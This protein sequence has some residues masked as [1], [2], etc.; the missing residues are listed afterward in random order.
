ML[1]SR[2]NSQIQFFEDFKSRT[3][4]VYQINYMMHFLEHYDI[5]GKDVLE[6]GGALP[7]EF[8]IDFLG[9]KSWTCTE[10]SQYD[11]A[12]NMEANQHH[13]TSSAQHSDSYVVHVKNIEDFEPV[14]DERFDCIFSVA[15][16]EHIG[17]LP[18]ALETMYRVLKPGGVLFSL[19]APIWSCATG[20]HLEHISIPDR[21]AG[22][23][24]ILEPWEHLL[25]NRS[26]LYRDLISKFDKSFADRV[27]Y[28]VFNNPFINRYHSEDYFEL[29]G[30]SK[31]IVDELSPQWMLPVPSD[32][33]EKLERACFGYKQF[34]NMGILC[35]VH[36]PP[37]PPL[38]QAQSGPGA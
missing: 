2:L 8:V 27:V 15:C 3:Q 18:E 25:K 19:Y 28:E 20:H 34:S 30:A 14:F 32:T 1:N 23:Q 10:S 24:Q 11:E 5:E 17:R 22:V 9:C 33:Q 4:L 31:F 12:L 35:R 6:V 7:K 38:A 37:E 21:F 26:S 16:F 29:I 13:K 36:K